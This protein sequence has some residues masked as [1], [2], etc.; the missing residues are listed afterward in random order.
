MRRTLAALACAV[1]LCAASGGCGREIDPPPEVV[2]PVPVPDLR[3]RWPYLAQ[4]DPTPAPAVTPLDPVRSESMA[5]PLPAVPPPVLP[6]AAH[7]LDDLQRA[8]ASA[9]GE[10]GVVHRAW[11]LSLT[12]APASRTLLQGVDPEGLTG[13][14]RVRYETLC[15]YLGAHVGENGEAYAAL[16]RMEE[17]L[18]PWAPLS[19]PELCLIGEPTR[20]FGRPFRIEARAEAGG[21]VGVYAQIDR[22]ACRALEGGGYR[23]S[24]EWDLT[25]LDMEGKVVET[26]D[27][28]ER[29]WGKAVTA[30]LPRYQTDAYFDLHGI[31]L[32]SSIV[33][34]RYV[35]VLEV[36][37]RELTVYRRAATGR[38][39]LEIR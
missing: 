7:P 11:V 3:E 21:T 4:V 16:A 27:G 5:P 10:D 15:T 8:L 37:D 13:L 32:P 24:I 28:I 14:A 23:V 6:A 12:D 31:P 2:P 9:Q 20:Q 25:L 29:A 35:L 30:S 26:F 36:V 22:P 39:E 1:A 18:R 33:P 34:G 19:V 38:L 17:L